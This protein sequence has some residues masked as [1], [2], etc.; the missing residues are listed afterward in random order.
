[1]IELLISAIDPENMYDTEEQSY[2]IAA[3]ASVFARSTV[4]EIEELD[5]IYPTTIQKMIENKGN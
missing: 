1:M 4:D 2:R 3:V 5:S